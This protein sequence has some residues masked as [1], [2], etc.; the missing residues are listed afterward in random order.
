L[1]ETAIKMLGLD[2]IV[3]RPLADSSIRRSL[4]ILRKNSRP[5]S[6]AAGKLEDRIFQTVAALG[7]KAPRP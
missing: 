6:P 1:P 3:F 5:N 4:Q 2:D 7:H